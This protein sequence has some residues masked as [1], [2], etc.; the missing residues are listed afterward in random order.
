MSGTKWS[1]KAYQKFYRAID[2][3]SKNVAA[4]K[5]VPARNGKIILELGSELDAEEAISA[6]NKKVAVTKY[7]AVQVKKKMPKII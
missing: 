3:D 7:K 2:E 4:K 6:F 5:T 1:R